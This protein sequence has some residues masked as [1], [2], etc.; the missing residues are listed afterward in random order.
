MDY[1][2]D[3]ELKFNHYGDK[4]LDVIL[5]Y[6][7]IAPVVSSTLYLLLCYFGPKI[8]KDRKAFDLRYPLAAW[9]LALS[10]FSTMGAIRMVPE[11]LRI[12]TTKT[13]EESICDPAHISYGCGASGLWTVVFCISKYPELLDTVFIVLRK[14]QLIFLHWYHHL[15]VLLFCWVAYITYSAAGHYF[16]SMNYTVHA[17]M[18]FYFF[19]QAIRMVPKGFPSWCITVLQITQMMIGTYVVFSLVYYDIYGGNTYAP[20]ECNNEFPVIVAGS[21]MYSSYLY[22]FV[23]FAVTKYLMAPKTKKE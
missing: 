21:I 1:F 13:F 15:T 12:V 9:N 8:M 23:Y 2:C 14:K 5:D 11:T 22:L 16:I 10:L 18:Y 4:I 17:V 20:K 6:Y 3:W 19:L 7:I